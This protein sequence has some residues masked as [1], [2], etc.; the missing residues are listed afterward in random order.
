MAFAT[1]GETTR[2]GFHWLDGRPGAPERVLSP[3]QNQRF[4]E[5][6]YN[7]SVESDERREDRQVI[8]A[9]SQVVSAIYESSEEN[10]EIIAAAMGKNNSSTLSLADIARSSGI[11]TNR[12]GDK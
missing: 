1:G 11:S 2:T 12:R 4:Q 6:L 9:L 3:G 7:L 8:E 5:L 10:A